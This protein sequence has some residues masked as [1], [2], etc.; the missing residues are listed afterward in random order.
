MKFLLPLFTVLLI[1]GNANSLPTTPKHPTHNTYHGVEVIDNYQWLE[2]WDSEKVKKWSEI[3]NTYA[4]EYIKKIPG[5]DKIREE[6]RAIMTADTVS[7]WNLA[8]RPGKLFAMMRVPSKQQAFLVVM[9]SANQPDKIRELVDPNIIDETH[10]TTI[11]WYYPSPDGTLVAVSMSKGGSE[12]GDLY[13]YDVGTGKTKYETITGVNGGTAGGNLGWTP[14]NSGFYYTRYPRRQERPEEDMLFYVQVYFHKLGTDPAE[15]TLEI[16]ENFTRIAEIELEVDQKTGRVLC[17]VQNGDGGEFAHYLRNKTGNWIQFSAFGDRTLQ[18][19]F[20][21]NNDL[22]IL[23]RKDAPRGKIEG[24]SISALP[25]GPRKL[26]IPESED[27]IVNSFWDSPSVLPMKDTLV[28]KYQLGGPSELRLFDLSGTFIQKPDLEP[29]SAVFGMVALNSEELL[30]ATNSFIEPVTWKSFNTKTKKTA[31]TGLFSKS[32][33]NFDDAEV[34]REFAE[35]KDGTKVPVN[36]IRLRDDVKDG[37]GAAVVYGYG[38]YGVS[39][40]PWFRAKVRILLD[41][42]ISFVVV[43]TRG[44]GEYGEEWHLSGNLLNKQNVFDDFTA[45]I[46]HMINQNYA[47]SKR[48]GIIGGSNGGL[49]MGATVVQHPKL[50]K[51]V[52]S[53]VGIYDMLRVE[54]SPNGVFNITEFGTVKDPD[55]FKALYAYSPY[56]NVKDGEKYPAILMLT[57]A[58][59]PRVDPMQSRKFTARLQATGSSEPILLRTSSDT[60]HGSGTPLTERIEQ[61]AAAYAFLCHKLGGN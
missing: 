28:V 33:V 20:G 50:V 8:S 18:A 23:S 42:G 13:I 5:I 25:D 61:S 51:A 40:D 29:V 3:Q 36:I 59:D 37:T 56:H 58:N 22:Y 12:S 19:T 52:V 54:L 47:S 49:L 27:T 26:L 10:S 35:S 45:A 44:G 16:G 43:N 6:I 32:P 14:D 30:F 55:Q 21:A 7:Y 60:G 1:A 11:D 24:I 53:F 57:G 31:D 38:G 48:L 34:I 15:D 46:N 17:T 9:P 39:L 2:D 41:R 4:R